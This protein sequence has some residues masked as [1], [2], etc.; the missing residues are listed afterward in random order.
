LLFLSFFPFFDVKILAKCNPKLKK[1]KKLI[2]LTLGKKNCK[3]F[4]I[5]LSRNSE[6]SPGKKKKLRV[7]VLSPLPF[8]PTY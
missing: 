6:I 5:S 7:R 8:T 2:E 3:N 1:L 4:P